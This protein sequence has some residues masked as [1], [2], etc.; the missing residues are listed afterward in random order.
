MRRKNAYKRRESSKFTL[1]ILIRYLKIKIYSSD[2]NQ[3][4][5]AVKTQQ[6]HICLRVND[7]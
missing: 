7:Q 5:N 1:K 6:E 3:P 4:K 2:I